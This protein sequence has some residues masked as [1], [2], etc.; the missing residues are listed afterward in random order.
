MR[1]IKKNN[2]KKTFVIIFE[3]LNVHLT[4]DVGSIP[5]VLARDYG[6]DSYLVC[7]DIGQAFTNEYV[8]QFL[9]IIKLKQ[10]KPLQSD[11]HRKFYF[12]SYWL[13]LFRNARA[14]DILHLYHYTRASK[15]TA[16]MYKFLNPKGKVYLK[17][18]AQPDIVKR[19]DYGY[20]TKNVFDVISAE[21]KNVFDGL[22]AA[23]FKQNPAKLV[24]I[25]NGID[26]LWLRQ[27]GFSGVAK[28]DK[29]NI[30][31]T[32][33][34]I[35]SDQ[36]NNAMALEAMNGVTLGNWKFVFIGPI[37]KHFSDAVEAFYK[38]NPRLKSSVIFTGEI[39]DRHE[40]FSWYKRA[41]CFCL[42]SIWEGFP[43]C[44]CEALYFGCEIISTPI[45]ALPDITN[46]GEFG[47]CVRN[48]AEL[49]DLLQ[50]IT[51]GQ[52]D[53]TNNMEKITTH[54]KR[55]YWTE[56]CGKLDNLCLKMTNG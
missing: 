25:P 11:A 18:D 9:D 41:K 20:F 27:N 45:D 52:I 34:R 44:L 1:K 31:I 50:K 10:I 7:H 24:H 39:A 37:E 22:A 5:Y 19:M 48:S 55:F 26:D 54:G 14:I 33:G 3:A 21:I 4:K 12:L 46:N 42:T 40:I 28:E 38:T 51:N 2:G 30:I 17:L 32:V 13:F 29:E 49:R 16:V 43:L 6:Y 35:G 8:T 23:C 53:P 56:I 15:I 36:K 47:H